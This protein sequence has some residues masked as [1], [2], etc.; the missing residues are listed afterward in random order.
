M[1]GQDVLSQGLQLPLP[2]LIALLGGLVSPFVGVL[3]ERTGQKL[4]EVWF[5]LISSATLGS[6]Y[7]LYQQLQA[8]ANGVLLLYSWGQAPPLSGCF[9]IDMLSVYMAFSIAF[10]GLLVSI[11]SIS[12][13]EH[14]T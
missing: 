5:I 11:Y 7:M 2:L 13:I 9:E 1:V 12:Y 14:E 10:L 4:R 3:A 6:V 8:T